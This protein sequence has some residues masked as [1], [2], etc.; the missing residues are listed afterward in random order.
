MF[1]PLLRYRED[2]ELGLSDFHC[3]VVIR[4]G[5]GVDLLQPLLVFRL[6]NTAGRNFERPGHGCEG[7]VQVARALLEFGGVLRL[8]DIANRQ[9]HSPQRNAALE[10]AVGDRLLQAGAMVGRIDGGFRNHLIGHHATG[11]QNAEQADGAKFVT[12]AIELDHG[13]EPSVF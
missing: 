4:D 8:P 11:K 5:K 9:F 3:V 12:N 1:A 6:R 13:G 10:G 7:V 2:L